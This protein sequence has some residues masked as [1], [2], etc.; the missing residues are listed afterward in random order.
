MRK[1]VILLTAM[2]ICLSLSFSVMAR[3]RRVIRKT[4]DISY[5]IVLK[6]GE[7]FL[8]TSLTPFFQIGKTKQRAKS[9]AGIAL[10]RKL[11]NMTKNPDFSGYRYIIS[12]VIFE[13]GYAV[14]NIGKATIDHK[15]IEILRFK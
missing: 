8:R 15:K 3:D 9:L 1:L 14:I 12:K 10:Q 11:L 7:V 6:D 2:V 5:E 4:Q 13:N